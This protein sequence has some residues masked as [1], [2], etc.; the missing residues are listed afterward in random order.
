M[1]RLVQYSNENGARRVALAGEDTT[2]LQL[3][4]GYERVYDLALAAIRA[5]KP[6]GS[7]VQ[8][9]LSQERVDYDRLIADQW[10]LPPLDHPDPARTVVSLTGLTHLGS[11]SSRDQMHAAVAAGAATDSIR[12]FQIGVQGG[13]P[14]DGQIGAQPEW[15]YKGDG[16]CVVAPE[17][18]LMQPAFADDGGEEAE[19]AGLYVI[20]DDGTPWRVGFAI[21]N[22]FS[23]HVLE[24][25]NYLYLAHS[26]L[27]L[28]AFGPE[29]L[30]G[31]LP[32]SL[33][34]TIRIRRDGETVWSSVFESGEAHMCH[35]IANL[36]HHHFKYELFRRP[37]DVHVH[38]FG[39][40]RVSFGDNF[41]TLDGDVFEVDVPLFGR[42][43]RNPLRVASDRSLVQ[44]RVI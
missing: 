9:C 41:R 5:G 31:A 30:V 28:C 7:F 12:M 17:H 2:T 26:K 40:N 11:A 36:E 43:L 22:E 32:E 27:R 34:G 3:V 24:R 8:E 33:N 29:L 38:F 44:V 35:T 4:D 15:A 1:I 16:R 25:K 14:A 13:K 21:G 6:L 19:I 37:G 23:D 18:P 20:A 39:A 42:P 10:L